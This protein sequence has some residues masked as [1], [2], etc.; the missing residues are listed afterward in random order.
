VF[1]YR[2]ESFGEYLSDAVEL[3]RGCL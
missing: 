2:V 3:E 1:R